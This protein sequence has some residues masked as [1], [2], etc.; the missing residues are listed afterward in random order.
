M[1]T[2]T[3]TFTIDVDDNELDT[4]NVQFTLIAAPAGLAVDADIHAANRTDI[5][6]NPDRYAVWHLGDGGLNTNGNNEGGGPN[7]A[8]FGTTVHATAHR[9]DGPGRPY[10]PTTELTGTWVL[11][12]AQKGTKLNLTHPTIDNLRM[13]AEIEE[14]ADDG[15]LTLAPIALG[16]DD[17]LAQR[18]LQLLA[19]C[20]LT[21]T[22]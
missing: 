8:V 13:T 15:T 16:P 7:I 6:N 14:I 10:G 2:R 12:N 3:L 5:D 11:P 17:Q 18:R 20:G 9:P 1:G 21:P 19:A 22:T 4:N